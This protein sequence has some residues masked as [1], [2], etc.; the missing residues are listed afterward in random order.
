MNNR[1]LLLIGGALAAA[2]L[3]ITLAVRQ[4]G[5][6]VQPSQADAAASEQNTA[7]PA[8]AQTTGQ[9]AQTTF[10]LQGKGQLST[11]DQH[12][13][14]DLPADLAADLEKRRIPVSQLKLIP[15]G[16]GGY[17]LPAQGQYH[18]VVMMYVGEDGKLHREERRVDPIPDTTLQVPPP[19]PQ[20][21]SANTTNQ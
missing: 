14:S 20:A 3:V 1:Q 18:T 7:Q 9:P 15:D 19:V 8:P 13:Q 5:V 21:P 17:H 6:E 10:T 2:A 11:H 12:L 16:K 4:A